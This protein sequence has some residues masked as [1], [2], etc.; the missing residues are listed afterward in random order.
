MCMFRRS[1]FVLLSYLF[2]LFRCLF[3]FDVR[4]QLTSLVSPNSSIVFDDLFLS[5]SKELVMHNVEGTTVTVKCRTAII[6]LF[7]YFNLC[8]SVNLDRIKI[9]FLSQSKKDFVDF[10]VTFIQPQ[11]EHR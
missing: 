7:L 1:L 10:S 6:A 9:Y 2:W 4:I 11:S 3:F 8:L 5:T